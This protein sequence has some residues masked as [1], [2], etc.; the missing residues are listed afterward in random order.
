MTTYE[1][2]MAGIME[3]VKVA[4]SKAHVRACRVYFNSLRKELPDYFEGAI[5][6]F[7]KGYKP[8]DDGYIR[9]YSLYQLLNVGTNDDE[10]NSAY[11]EFDSRKMTPFR[12]GYSGKDGLYTQVFLK[13]WHGGADHISPSKAE[14]WGAHPNPGTPYWRTPRIESQNTGAIYYPHWGEEAEV[15]E[16][17]PFEDFRQRVEE[18][19]LTTAQREF[20]ENYGKFFQEEISN[21]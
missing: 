4:A 5:Q 20:T 13:G 8:K 21:V 11:I 14:K 15:A 12:S 2:I 10:Y 3:R 17:S 7:Y 18:F 6:T 16:M 19:R 1:K 9:N